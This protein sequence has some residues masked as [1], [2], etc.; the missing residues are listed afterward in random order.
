LPPVGFTYGLSLKRDNE[1]AYLGKITLKT[2]TT[3][4]AFSDL[5]K[6]KRQNQ[7]FKVLNKKAILKGFLTSQVPF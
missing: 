5:S 4:W 7:D 1:D 3:N 6:N 2:V